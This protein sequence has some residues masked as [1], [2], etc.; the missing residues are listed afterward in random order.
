MYLDMHGL[1]FETSI[2]SWKDQ[3]GNNHRAASR[4]QRAL[5]QTRAINNSDYGN[6]KQSPRNVPAFEENMTRNVESAA[7]VDSEAFTLSYGTAR[8]PSA[9]WQLERALMRRERDVGVRPARH[10]QLP[11]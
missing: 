10:K 5:Q 8:K 2:Y 7:D 9:I 6:N 3:P 4:Q 1:I 11:L